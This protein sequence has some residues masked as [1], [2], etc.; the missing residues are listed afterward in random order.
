MENSA[1]LVFGVFCAAAVALFG[2][3]K[4][5]FDV[6]TTTVEFP[7]SAAI[8]AVDCPEF[9]LNVGDACTVGSQT[10]LVSVE[11][12]CLDPNSIEAITLE[13]SNELGTE[14]VVTV[15]TVHHARH[16]FDASGS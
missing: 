4:E 14:L 13:F 2:C 7:N 9:M 1:T 5:V 16:V 11:C 8:S 3:K 10:G 12:E 15:E 6:T